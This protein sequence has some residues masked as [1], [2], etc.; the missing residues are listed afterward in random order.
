MV[1]GEIV[2]VGETCLLP[3][4]LAL[5]LEDKG[6][7]TWASPKAHLELAKKRRLRREELKAEAEMETKGRKRKAS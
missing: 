1:N 4:S 3:D 7:V 6:L 5:K 2:K